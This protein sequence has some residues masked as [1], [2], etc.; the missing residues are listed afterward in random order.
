[1]KLK[2]TCSNRSLA[3]PWT[4]TRLSYITIVLLQTN[5][6]LLYIH[7]SCM[8]L[9]SP[10][11]QEKS[12]LTM[13]LPMDVGLFIHLSVILLCRRNAKKNKNQWKPAIKTTPCKVLPFPSLFCSLK[14]CS[15]VC[16][17]W[18]F[19]RAGRW[20]GQLGGGGGGGGQEILVGEF[21]RGK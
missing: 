1:M 11:L 21:Y 2:A 13:S 8:K 14:L 18:E 19:G 12:H 4:Q 9:V 15:V 16:V 6:S 5:V 10:R 20:R 7:V 3:W 17:G